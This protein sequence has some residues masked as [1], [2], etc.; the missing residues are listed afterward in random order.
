MSV[1]LI[2]AGLAA[3][4]FLALMG[5]AVILASLARLDDNF[6]IIDFMGIGI[7]IPCAWGLYSYT[8]SC[9]FSYISI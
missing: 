5:R 7:W 2:I 9:S 4:A 1:L 3:I 6:T 8:V